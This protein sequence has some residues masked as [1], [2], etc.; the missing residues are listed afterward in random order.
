MTAT[1]STNGQSLRETFSAWNAE[2][3]AIDSQLGESLEALAAY[4]SHLDEWQQQLAAE[5][6]EFR[7]AQENFERGRRQIEATTGEIDGQR[8][9]LIDAQNALAAERDQLQL[10]QQNFER[11]ERE[12]EAA[13]AEVESS[14]CAGT[15]GHDC[16]SSGRNQSTS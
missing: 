8:Q 14:L 12:L 10:S 13:R 2:R 16:Y 7:Q 6:G 1:L 4:Q 3:N 11:G 15:A 9:S 5:R